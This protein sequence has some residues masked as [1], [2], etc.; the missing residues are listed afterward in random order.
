MA[1]PE[2]IALR[3]GVEYRYGATCDPRVGWRRRV[4]NGLQLF[5]ALFGQYVNQRSLT[6]GAGDYLR[7]DGPV[8]RSLE[9]QGLTEGAE[10]LPRAQSLMPNSP[11]AVYVHIPFCPSKCGYCD[12]NSY[13]MTG[14][15]VEQTVAATVRELE[16]SPFAGRPAKTIFFGGGTPTYLDEHQ[17]IRVFE[18][19]LR[20]HPPVEGCE[21]TS[22][23][24][25]G[26]V[27]AEKF[28][29]MRRAG[30]NRVSL[31]A[32]SF[33]DEDLIRLDRV[34][35]GGDIERAVKAARI[36]GFDNLNLD[37]MFALPHQSRQAWQRNLDRALA[38]A[39][40]H[41]SLYCLTIEE[42]T[43][44]YKKLIRGQLVLP[45]EDDQ[46]AMYEECMS[47][48]TAEGY[49]PYEISNFARPGRECQH[50]LEY[51]RGGEY[52]AY[53]PGAVGRVGGSRTTN[54]KHPRLYCEAVEAGRRPLLETEPLEAETL[55]VER[56]IFGLRLEE[57]IDTGK[58]ERKTIDELV[59]RGWVEASSE[60][61]KLT[62]EGR[63]FHN[64]VAAA[65]M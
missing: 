65:L 50:N 10:S 39:P 59:G 3:G 24:N 12:F 13:A 26:T 30:F 19:V 17:L 52:A 11:L 42:N 60:R 25:P 7:P 21:I 18:A 56:M 47:R 43:A 46:V 5:H 44:F 32:Q 16:T 51:W 58:L 8:R 54:L 53:G 37:L 6:G 28:G 2:M 48:M 31:G 23:A 15:I 4:R 1:L 55:D 49:V 20:A 34:H 45:D 61:L 35:K 33:V 27:D 57:G 22:E 41:L 38:L 62:R 29:A 40:E 64:E 14:D 63:H 9:S 36:A